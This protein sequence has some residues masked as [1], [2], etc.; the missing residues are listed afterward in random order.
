LLSGGG[1]GGGGLNTTTSP[2]EVDYVYDD[3]DLV[4]EEIYTGSVEKRVLYQYDA[5]ENIVEKKVIR[6]TREFI[7]TYTYDANDNITKVI[8]NGT[9]IM[10]Y[11]GLLKPFNYQID[12]VYNDEGLVLFEYY[13]G[14][15]ERTTEYKY[16]KAGNVT[17]K[18]VNVNGQ[19]FITEYTYNS[20]GSVIHVKDNGSDLVIVDGDFSDSFF[21]P[22]VVEEGHTHLNKEILDALT[23]DE[24]G[25]LLFRGELIDKNGSNGGGNGTNVD[26]KQITKLGVVATVSQPKNYILDIPY[27]YD[28]LRLPLEVLKFKSG[29]TNITNTNVTF[30][31][32]DNNDFIENLDA[33]FESGYLTINPYST[34]IVPTETTEPTSETFLFRK[35]IDVQSLR[36]KKII[37]FS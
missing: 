3:R 10:A 26:Y 31:N 28:F 11:D 35:K 18:I 37:S 14:D 6:G 8:D 12:F 21:E 20:S 33:K 24:M 13:T 32:N 36:N 29:T 34:T 17:F 23:V 5:N 30:D 1:S 2:F 22:P 16:N 9:E 27:T 15:I 4:I 19:Q 25:N 7:A